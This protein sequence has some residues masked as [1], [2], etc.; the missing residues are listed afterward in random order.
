MVYSKAY[1][2]IILF[3]LALLSCGSDDNLNEIYYQTLELSYPKHLVTEEDLTSCDFK[4]SYLHENGD[5]LR[6]LAIGNSFTYDAVGNYLYELF[7]AENI[8]VFIGCLTINGSSLAEHWQNSQTD[9]KLYSYTTRHKNSDKSTTQESLKETLLSN[10]WDI[11]TLQQVSQLSGLY[12]SYE[13]YLSNL[14]SWISGLCDAGIL[15]HQTWAYPKNSKYDY[16]KNYNRNQFYMYVSILEASHNVLD[17]NI[18]IVNIIPSGTAV[19]NGRTSYLGDTFNRD[20]LHLGDTYGRFTAACTWFEVISGK[21]IL[22]N[23]YSPKS[24]SKEEETIVKTAV[25]L[26]V[27]Y[28][29]ILCDLGSLIP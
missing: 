1:L 16:F 27:K 12:S 20:D 15:F 18:N 3:S 28:P 13:P 4:N 26:A 5:T 23:P 22:D 6:I 11:I 8:P 14:I 17:N 10:E 2:L 7:E 19:Q 25:H 21:C 24:V 9:E 29:F